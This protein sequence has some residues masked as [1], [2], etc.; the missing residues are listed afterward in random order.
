MTF[1]LLPLRRLLGLGL[2]LGLCGCVPSTP[3][4]ADEEKEPYFQRGKALAT[5]L[6]YRGAIEAFEKALEVNPHNAQAHFEL[7]LLYQRDETDLPAAVYHFERFLL[8]R[9]Q[10]DQADLVRRQIT[11][12]KQDLARTVSISMAPITQNMQRDLERLTAEKERLTNEKRELQQQLEAW[13]AYGARLAPGGVPA[14]QVAP[15]APPA[16]DPSASTPA[17]RNPPAD[18]SPPVTSR[19]G[20]KSYVVKRGESLYTIAKKHGV[21]L[22]RLQAANPGVEARKL[23]AGQTLTIPAP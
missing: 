16:S 2:C 6:D 17:S 8:L 12:C 21:K 20:T 18:R 14:A 23:R 22:S 1:R 9:P 4:R 15:T 13:Q 5:S 19:S 3:N 10:S 7:G 11:A